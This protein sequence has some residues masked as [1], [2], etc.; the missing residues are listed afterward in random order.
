MSKDPHSLERVADTLVKARAARQAAEAKTADAVYSIKDPDAREKFI[1]KQDA[2]QAQ[3]E[4]DVRGALGDAFKK[5][6]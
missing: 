5:R 6:V 1:A 2:K 3:Y 4:A